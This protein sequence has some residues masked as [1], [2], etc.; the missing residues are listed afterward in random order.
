LQPTLQSSASIPPLIYTVFSVRCLR[1]DNTYHIN[2]GVQLCAYPLAKYGLM[3]QC[4]GHDWTS[5]FLFERVISTFLIESSLRIGRITFS[6]CESGSS[7][8]QRYVYFLRP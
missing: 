4:I 7:Q 3:Q 1:N 6:F 8:V 5:H 2:K